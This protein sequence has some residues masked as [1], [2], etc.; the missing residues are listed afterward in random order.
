MKNGK[1]KIL[2][3]SS[4]D[5]TKGPGVL[6]ADYYDAFKEQGFE[7]DVLTLNY[8]EAH[9]EFL[10]VQNPRLLSSRIRAK[11]KH[12]LTRLYRLYL[13]LFHGFLLRPEDGHSFFYF[14]EENPPVRVSKVLSRIKKN[15]DIV[16]IVFW[17]EMISFA[18]VLAI[19]RKLHCLIF[20]GG[21][22]YSQM[23]GGCHFTRNCEKFKTGCGCCT[24][25]HSNDPKDFT[26]HNVLYRQKVY[27]EVKP[28]VCGNSYMLEYY[29]QSFLLNNYPCTIS[30]PIINTSLFRPMDKGMLQDK[31]EISKKKTFKILF[32]CQNITDIRKGIPYLIEA[33]NI[34]I[35]RL[36]ESERLQVLV[37]AIGK[38]FDKAK[39]QL[40]AV[41]TYDFGY[42]SGG[43]LPL[44]YSLADVFICPSV[45]DAG[46]MMVN[47]SLCCGT[48][49][50]GFEMGACLDAVKDK[51]TGYCAPLRDSQGLSVGIEKIFRQ[52][53]EERDAMQ[54]RCVELAQETYSYEAC[55]KRI[56][57]EYERRNNN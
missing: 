17:Q 24:A 16:Y 11:I 55:V 20:F 29:R 28:V 38:D 45:D 43:E 46:P 50:V 36:T 12:N 23:S 9:P 27:D 31:Y 15:Y 25:F 40:K 37:M 14:K 35:E 2:I 30:F 34:F 56:V 39:A 44:I 49:V 1:P 41:D 6:A 10:Y 53:P 26:K 21:V 57:D 13:T 51:G 7:V 48:P 3:L 42:V 5:P 4:A 19:F 33:I 32:G 18:S 22:D 54:R 8:C 47:Q 52:T